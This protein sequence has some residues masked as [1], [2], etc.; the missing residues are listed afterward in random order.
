[1]ASA[2]VL[3]LLSGP[4]LYVSTVLVEEDAF[5]ALADDVLAHPETR[6]AVAEIVTTVTIEAVTSDEALTEA[7][8]AQVRTFTVPLTRLAASQLTDVAFIALDTQIAIDARDSALRE[9]HREFTADDDEITID[10][11]AVL[12]RTSRELG[13]PAIGAGVAKL[14]SGSDAGQFTLT[15]PGSATAGLVGVV[16]TVPAIG[17]LLG[18]A[19]LFSLV[20]SILLAI[21]RRRALIT[22]GLVVAS[23]AVLSTVLVSVALYVVLAVVAGGSSVGMAAADVVSADFAQ[24]QRGVMFNGLVLAV[25]GL[26]LG[27]RASAVALRALPG[28]LWHRRPGAAS[29]FADIVG[30]NPAFARLAGWAGGAFVLLT[31]S[32]PTWR[33]LIS[34]VVC[35]GGFQAFVWTVTS[36]SPAAATVRERFKIDHG[37]QQQSGRPRLRVNVALLGFVVFLLWPAWTRTTTVVAVVLLALVQAGLEIRPARRT[38]KDRSLPTPA[39]SPRPRRHYVMA[40]SAIA[41][42]LALGTL[43]TSGA[44]ER[45]LA[46]TECNGAVELCDRR[47]DEVTFAGSHNA[48]SSTELGWELALQDG[49]MVAQLDHGIRALLI[50]ALYWTDEGS[51]EGEDQGASATIEAALSDTQP[52]PG[53]WLCHGFCA[54][55]AT[56]LTSGL[57]EINLW[58]SEHP[59]EVLI[60]IVQDEV[61]VAD[62][63]AAFIESGLR[64]QAYLHNPGTPYP[65]LQAMIDADQRVLIYG[66]N[67]GQPGTWF[68]NGY[69]SS[70]Q[71]TPFTFAVR[72]QFTCA[73]N[74]GDE[75]NSLFLINHWLTTGIP[76]REA[77]TI[78]NSRDVLMERVQ[79][80]EID[81]GRLPT[82]LATDFVETGDLISVVDE[83]NGL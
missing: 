54:L 36:H 40:A 72:S 83:L 38:A 26:M 39:P 22:G 32:S 55:G 69:E 42:A 18:F 70:I 50:D 19:S 9:V 53:T 30:D 73:P 8:P 80:C 60:I 20:S 21:D 56:E 1:M 47:I 68:Q 74:R 46:S 15:E 51:F 14:V 4:A 75:E 23:A 24:Q 65:T 67:Q 81:R 3:A 16:Q 17:A 10:L 79:E 78:V 33:V 45:N 37:G 31:W 62:L 57:A 35:V 52:R 27:D 5:V 28:D 76:V 6:R 2:F 44:T 41:I 58:L 13:G 77:A 71:E 29:R 7:L 12:V 64:E 59:R 61:S 43:S 49:D 48:M 25:V 34:I 66:E 82:I 11:R 63:E